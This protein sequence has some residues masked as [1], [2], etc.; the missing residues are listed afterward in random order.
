VKTEPELR[1]LAA[2]ARTAAQPHAEAALAAILAT[3]TLDPTLTGTTFADR[4]RRH[5]ADPDPALT[6]GKHTGIGLGVRIPPDATVDPAR[7]LMGGTGYWW[8]RR[9]TP[10]WKVRDSRTHYQQMTGL[11]GWLVA[12]PVAVLI[13]AANIAAP[14]AAI[15]FVGGLV[16]PYAL[17][18]VTVLGWAALAVT[19]RATHKGAGW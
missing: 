8:V 10:T 13:I 2:R 12:A 14:L 6:P 18:G 7:T 4:E 3:L 5:E 11:F 15:P 16:A 9:P 1:A 19:Y 17:A